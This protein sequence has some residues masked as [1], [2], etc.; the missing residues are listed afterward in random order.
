MVVVVNLTALDQAR[1]N[2][3]PSRWLVQ[4]KTR[5]ILGTLPLKSLVSHDRACKR[6]WVIEMQMLLYGKSIENT[7]YGTSSP[8]SKRTTSLEKWVGKSLW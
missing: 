7:K 3:R 1:N 6:L 8:C 5:L 4:H 2:T